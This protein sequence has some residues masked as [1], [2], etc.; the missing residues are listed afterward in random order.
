[1]SKA[2]P[3]PSAD[4]RSHLVS[5]MA[6]LSNTRSLRF[7]EEFGSPS[8]MPYKLPSTPPT[9]LMDELVSCMKVG[10]TEP[11][12]QSIP[13]HV[14]SQLQRCIEKDDV[15]K[16]K[17]IHANLKM[18]AYRIFKIKNSPSTLS[19]ACAMNATK[20]ARFLL[21]EE[22]V[23]ALATSLPFESCA[24]FFAA[25][26]NSVDCLKILI[27][28]TNT[29]MN[30]TN[31]RGETLLHVACSSNSPQ[32]LRYLL[33]RSLQEA[34]A[35][36]PLLSI[37]NVWNMTPLHT[38]VLHG[39]EKC[40]EELLRNFGV[41]AMDLASNKCAH[42]FTPLHIAAMCIGRKMVSQTSS[43]P[44]MNIVKLLLEHGAS[45]LNQHNPL[46]V[47]PL[48]LACSAKFV[49]ITGLLLKTSNPHSKDSMGLT[50]LHVAAIAND[51]TSCMLLM[52][53]GALVTVL[54]DLGETPIHKA[55]ALNNA[56]ILL[57]LLSVD[58]RPYPLKGLL[59]H[60]VE[61]TADCAVEILLQ[62]GADVS[63]S[64]VRVAQ[65]ACAEALVVGKDVSKATSVAKLLS[66]SAKGL[67]KHNPNL[68][69]SDILVG[70]EVCKAFDQEAAVHI[71]SFC[72]RNL[73]SGVD[74][75]SKPELSGVEIVSS[76]SLPM[77]R[78]LD[79]SSDEGSVGTITSESSE[80]VFESACPMPVKKRLRRV[81]PET[82]N[83]SSTCRSL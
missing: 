69:K 50:P 19:V 31:E 78:T 8:T 77:K 48:H 3:P 10:V 27:E 47:T 66:A 7:L 20:I 12:D 76:N 59:S 51:L 14:T 79:S 68:P 1:M 61:A 62:A 83:M 24:A 41:A 74:N 55:A 46:R 64:D 71:M 37:Q 82:K 53:A 36:K 40:V 72:D 4:Y 34:K 60:A 28:E 75:T 57:Y 26:S 5:P 9:T 65:R 2:M 23:D 42:S 13:Y 81:T 44:S 33:G 39:S 45:T 21:Q 6:K 52:Q 54:D 58:K 17:T 32:A 15:A 30:V 35:E 73:F 18:G 25:S 70:D 29:P 38:A 49:P 56:E 80:D 63:E 67:C 22:G 43:S 16:F 11:S